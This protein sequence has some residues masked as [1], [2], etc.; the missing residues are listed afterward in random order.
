MKR[1]AE[2][3]F[4]TAWGGIA[5][6]SIALPVMHTET[7]KRG[8]ALTDI[9]RWMSEAPAKLASCHTRKGR[10]AAGYDADFVVFEPESEFVVTEGRL[11]YRHPVS[12]Y[13]GEK[14]RGVV[15]ANYLRG[16][17]VFG[18]GVFPGEPIG[19]EYRR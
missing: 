15:R 4:R 17:K 16:R 7:A 8:F 12:P 1:L 11:H 5:S 9:A 19:E 10:L 6:L 2:G 18:D 13:L 3:N 14:L